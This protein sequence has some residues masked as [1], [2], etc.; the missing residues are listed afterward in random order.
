MSSLKN[1]QICCR[2]YQRHPWLGRVCLIFHEIP[3][4]TGLLHQEVIILWTR[5]TTRISK[6]AMIH[7]CWRRFLSAHYIRDNA[8]R[9]QIDEWWLYFPMHHKACC[10]MKSVQV[11]IYFDTVVLLCYALQSNFVYSL[12]YIDHAVYNAAFKHNTYAMTPL[13][14]FPLYS[15]MVLLL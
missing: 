6:C 13:F 12:W 15:F 2:H 8:M 11:W 14:A 4:N 9:R 1:F 3:L 10:Q 5:L 7:R